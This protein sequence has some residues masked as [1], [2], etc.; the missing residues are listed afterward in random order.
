MFRR[1]ALFIILA[2]VGAAAATAAPLPCQVQSVAAD[3]VVVNVKFEKPEWMKEGLHLRVVRVEKNVLIG[4]SMIIGVSDS[5]ITVLT[6]KGKAKNLK[7]GADITVD[8]PRAGM[9]GC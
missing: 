1:L 9:A 3:T 5:T 6:P 4:K 7:P 8:K 2:A